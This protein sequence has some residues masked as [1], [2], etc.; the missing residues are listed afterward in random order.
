MIALDRARHP[1]RMETM[2]PRLKQALIVMAGIVAVLW[3]IEGIDT[4]LRHALDS[5]GIVPRQLSGLSG[6]AVAPLLHAGF[7]HVAANSIPLFALGSVVWTEGIKRWLTT[8]VTTWLSSGVFAWL[9]GPA[10][11]VVIGASGVIFGLITYL[12]VRGFLSRSWILLAIG[13]VVMFAYGYALLGIFPWAVGPHVAWQGHLGGAL[14]GVLAAWLL[15][16][17]SRKTRTRPV[18]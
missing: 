2:L 3:L 16:R 9:I 13:L 4:L 1:W 14:G 11:A 7:A 6:I 12:I 10:Q 5:F 18:I 8:I 17:N 15:H